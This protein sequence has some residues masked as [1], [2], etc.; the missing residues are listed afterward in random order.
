MN[1]KD[2]APQS[3]TQKYARLF[4]D[5]SLGN[6]D[7]CRLAGGYTCFHC[8][9]HHDQ[10]AETCNEADGA[11]TVLCPSCGIDAC[12]PDLTP[13]VLAAAHRVQFS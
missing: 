9:S 1:N 12:I 5:L 4:S 11:Q 3:M 8:G 7:V 6:A 10:V 2:N 13:E